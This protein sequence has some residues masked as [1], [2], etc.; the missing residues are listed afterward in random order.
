[1]IAAIL[2]KADPEPLLALAA[3]RAGHGCEVCWGAS[4][5]GMRAQIGLTRSYTPKSQIQSFALAYYNIYSVNELLE[6][7]GGL[8]L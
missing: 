1:M 4:L 5:E 6:Y 2:K 7:I 8:V 3:G